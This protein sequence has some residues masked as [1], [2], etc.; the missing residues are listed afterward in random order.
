MES[1]LADAQQD[2]EGHLAQLEAAEAAA[3]GHQQQV[4]AAE[5]KAAAAASEA[6]AAVAAQQIAEGALADAEASSSILAQ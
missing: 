5:E 4:G 1:Q 3:A 6:A 2:A